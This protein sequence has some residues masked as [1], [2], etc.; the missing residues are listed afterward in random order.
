MATF[1]IYACPSAWRA[2]PSV[3]AALLK[4]LAPTR[5][6]YVGDDEYINKIAALINDAELKAK[7]MVI[8]I[9]HEAEAVAFKMMQ[10]EF[11]STCQKGNNPR[12][13]YILEDPDWKAILA[14]GALINGMVKDAEKR[15]EEIQRVNATMRQFNKFDLPMNANVE[16]LGKDAAVDYRAFTT[17]LEEYVERYREGNKAET[18][19][20]AKERAKVRKKLQSYNTYKAK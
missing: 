20:L 8:E 4:S 1:F 18:A 9:E 11:L 14:E 12:L 2:Q 15:K 19:K 10:T 7:A 17:K 16:L 3:D 5:R 13:K 6:F